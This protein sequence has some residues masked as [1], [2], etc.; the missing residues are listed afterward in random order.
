MSLWMFSNLIFAKKIIFVNKQDNKCIHSIW[1]NRPCNLISQ[2]HRPKIH[3]YIND[4]KPHCFDWWCVSFNH[5]IQNNY[6][7]PL[8]GF[9]LLCPSVCPCLCLFV[10][11]SCP[12]YNSITTACKAHSDDVSSRW[13]LTLAC[14]FFKLFPFKH[15]SA[16]AQW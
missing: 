13:T 6:G 3:F 10:T 7:S 11:K 5:C 4:I 16:V 15:V 8:E 2:G 9:F 14:L 1:H 12:L